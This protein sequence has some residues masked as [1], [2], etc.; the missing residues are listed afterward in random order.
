MEDGLEAVAFQ[1]TED[2]FSG[3]LLPPGTGLFIAHDEI[4]IVD[5]GEMKVEHPSVYRCFPHQTGVTERSI[6]GHDGCAADPIMDQMVISH[7]TNWISHGLSQVL[8]RQHHVGITY[9]I[10]LAYFGVRRVW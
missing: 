1:G 2:R 9:K 5:A 10:C 3:D 7:Q 4:L 6:S 8:D